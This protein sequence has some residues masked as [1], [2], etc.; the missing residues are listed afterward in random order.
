[1]FNTI[2]TNYDYK[3]QVYTFYGVFGLGL[4][5]WI[6]KNVVSE[7]KLNYLFRSVGNLSIEIDS[8]FL[9]ELREI[10]H[11]ILSKYKSYAFEFGINIRTIKNLLEEIN[12]N[13]WLKEDKPEN[14]SFL[15][16]HD[17]LKEIFVI[18]PKEFQKVIYS[19]YEYKKNILKNLGILLDSATGTGKTYQGLTLSEATC[20]DIIIYIV[21]G[22][23]INT[24]WYPTL[25]NNSDNFFRHKIDKD[26]I[27]TSED[28]YK[29]KKYNGEKHIL[30]H[31]EALEKLINI[32]NEFSNKNVTILVDEVH[33]FTTNTSNRFNYLE[34]LCKKTRSENI[35]LMSGT[36]IKG[37]TLEFVPYLQL[38]E[39]RFNKVVKE[40]YIK[41][42]G[43]PNELLKSVMQMRYKRMS[44]KIHK[45]VLE[46]K[47]VNYN[48]I[49]ISLSNGD[50]YTLKNVK[51]LMNKYTKERVEE[52]E[53]NIDQY[54]N[55]YNL[56]L[57]KAISLNPKAN[58]YKYKDD[59]EKI[60][61][62]YKKR[63][64]MF[65]MDL[66]KIINDFEKTNIHVFLTIEEREL[67][68]EA[69]MLL[70]YPMLKIRGEV[71]GK[72]FMRKRIEAHR[73]MC[74]V[75]NYN[76]IVNGSLGKTIIISD[77]IEIIEE[78]LIK[79]KSDGLNPIAVYGKYIKNIDTIM[80]KFKND[81][82]T[83]PLVGTYPAIG[84]GH[85]LVVANVILLLN[86]PF[87][88]YLLDQA[89]ARVNRMG[90]DKDVFIIY[91][92]L[93]TGEE[94]N[95]TSRNIDILKWAR[96]AVSDITGYNMTDLEF[97]TG[98]VLDTISVED[99][100]NY[101]EEEIMK[102]GFNNDILDLKNIQLNLESI[103]ILNR[104]TLTHNKVL[105][106]ESFDVNGKI[107]SIEELNKYLTHEGIILDSIKSIGNYLS[108]G[109]DK[110]KDSIGNLFT[111][112]ESLDNN[113]ILKDTQTLANEKTNYIKLHN[114]LI[115]KY[116]NDHSEIH[117][118]EADILKNTG[119]LDIP[120]TLGL[121]LNVKDSSELIVHVIKLINSETHKIV[122]ETNECI[123]KMI[124]DKDYRLS[125]K[126]IHF[127][128]D[129]YK[130]T[131]DM[132]E[133]LHKIIDPNGTKD[134][135]KL[136]NF[137]GN[138]DNF[139]KAA[140]NFTYKVD[141]N[142]ITRYKGVVDN[143]NKNIN[144]LYNFIKDNPDTQISSSSLSSLAYRIQNVAELLTMVGTIFYMYSQ[145]LISSI[146]V[147]YIYK[148]QMSKY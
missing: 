46:L 56:Y 22:K 120:V 26:N 83:N 99:Y 36:P 82:D 32:S 33:N 144:Y 84:T 118:I 97:E 145:L 21:M 125:T 92:N 48:T 138:F 63:Q 117:K 79:I 115:K 140:D 89:I 6:I 128:N 146:E 93:K 95:L 71:L 77:Y 78:A 87:R 1:M 16:D 66:M 88:P 124:G 135:M 19:E 59:F 134:R 43:S 60:K 127:T 113:F 44:V 142:L 52:I 27:Y 130:L 81:E 119:N 68:K 64:L 116:N 108:N 105:S 85:H 18:E 4:R 34:L 102:D 80:E 51:E 9:L 58:W 143:L 28:L 62:I 65:N 47:P 38:L 73:D 114:D 35:I 50:N 37:S 129:T 13:T 106:K 49:E 110:L 74:K 121:K 133:T 61:I 8:F 109:I 67:F 103:D 54:Q 11:I 148:T 76:P 30:I 2:R 101:K 126:P 25:A 86:L 132:Y 137:I 12:N 45:E 39:P 131:S 55:T 57:N 42:Y 98:E 15:I 10:L 24:V 72:V 123:M 96:D 29:N 41:I 107:V 104:I 17:R 75:I 69:S 31:Y 136:I 20:S 14:Y 139:S 3:R 91:V 5:S 122:D 94:Y 7:K 70:K 147:Y 112:T 111:K 23:N 90:Q 53:N 40:R 100:F 141:L